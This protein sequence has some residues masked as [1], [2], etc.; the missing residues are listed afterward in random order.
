LLSA[1]LSSPLQLSPGKGK[2]ATVATVAS[3]GML[4]AVG[5]LIAAP[6]TI[7]RIP[8]QRPIIAKWCGQK[9]FEMSAGLG[10]SLGD[11]AVYHVRVRFP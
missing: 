11:A 6:D 1:L 4:P 10:H 2:V 8:S 7:R 9:C 5:W 3:S